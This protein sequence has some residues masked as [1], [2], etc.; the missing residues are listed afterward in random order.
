MENNNL[1]TQVF[2][3]VI[4]DKSGSMTSIAK[5]AIEGFNE[6]VGGIR[7]KP[8]SILCLLYGVC[9]RLRSG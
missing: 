3:L 4:L 2:N 1:K 6:T 7:S 8:A 9:L 5:A